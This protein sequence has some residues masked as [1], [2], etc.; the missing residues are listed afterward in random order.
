MTIGHARH[1]ENGKYSNGKAGD[2]TKDEVCITS[3]YNRPW[4]VCLRAK[5]AEVR[6]K[7]ARAMEQ[8]CANNAIGYDQ[9]QRTTLYQKAKAVKWDLS[10]ITEPCETDCSALVAVCVNAAGINVSG[11][12]Y[13]GNE[14]QALLNT[15][16]F[17][18]LTDKKYLDNPNSLMRGDILLYEGHHT[19]V[20]LEDAVPHQGWLQVY[21]EW[22]Y[23]KDSKKFTKNDWELVKHHWYYF[24]EYGAMVTGWQR[25]WNPGR[26]E[27]EW[28]YFEDSGANCGRL[29]HETDKHNGSL[30]PWYVK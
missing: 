18:A 6:E 28:Y 23:S 15:K 26:K 2:Q 29:W 21:D 24:N 16:Q 14:K 3:W 10:K 12:I 25:I 20:A 30:E 17:V 1:D 22:L 13:T 8:A 7:I 5:T 4:N 9:N 19:A 27:E 11:D